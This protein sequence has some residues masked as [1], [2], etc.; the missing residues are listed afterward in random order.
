[1]KIVKVIKPD[2]R[3]EWDEWSFFFNIPNYPDK[4]LLKEPIN[5]E[6]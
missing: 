4:A 6:Q 1:M 2:N 5:Q 3:M